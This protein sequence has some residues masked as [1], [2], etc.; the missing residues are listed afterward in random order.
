VEVYPAFYRN[1]D[2]KPKPDGEVR[3]VQH[4]LWQ[5]RERV[6]AVLDQG[7]VVFVCGDGLH[8]A[9]A[10]RDTLTKIHQETAN[11]SDEA[12]DEWLQDMEDQSRY[13]PDVFA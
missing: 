7:A 9:P 6:R 8:M 13:V 11:C 1:S 10:V 5:E 4:R 3:F 2:G 12:A